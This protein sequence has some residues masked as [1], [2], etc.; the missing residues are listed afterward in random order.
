MNKS[1]AQFQ[2]QQEAQSDI[3]D[4]DELEGDSHHI[5]YDLV[6]NDVKATPPREQRLAPSPKG[7]GKH[8]NGV[9]F[10]QVARGFEPQIDKLL[11]TSQGKA[12]KPGQREVLV[13]LDSQSTA[14]LICN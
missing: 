5:Q 6:R 2:Q 14:D 13:L 1:F 8:H 9:Q 3:S 11:T 7:K 10:T 12:T 4:S